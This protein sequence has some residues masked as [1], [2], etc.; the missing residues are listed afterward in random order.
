MLM[1]D[2]TQDQDVIKRKTITVEK[3]LWKKLKKLQLEME[4]KNM[5]DLINELLDEYESQEE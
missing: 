3:W 1:A 2:D 4:H 5:T